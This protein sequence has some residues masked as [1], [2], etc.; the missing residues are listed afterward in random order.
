MRGYGTDSI[1]GTVRCTSTDWI[2]FIV[3]QG[4]CIIFTV[5]AV[6]VVNKEYNEKVECGYTFV[7]G[8]FKATPKSLVMMLSIAYFGAFAAAFCGIGPGAIFC[9]VLVIIGVQPLVATSTGMYVTFFTTF[10][11]SIQAIIFK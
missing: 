6:L 5:I 7:D 3:L 1:I 4:I 9:P 8:D 11:A 2:L 10:A